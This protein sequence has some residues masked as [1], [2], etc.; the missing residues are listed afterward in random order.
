MKTL[1]TGGGGFI[2][3][4]LTR[5]LLKAGVQVRIL[6]QRGPSEFAKS[7]LGDLLDE[8]EWVIGDVVQAWH[9]ANAVRGCDSV[10]HLAAVL[11]PFCQENPIRGAEIIVIGTLNMFEAARLHGI[12]NVIYTSSAG[13]FGPSDGTYPNPTTHYGAFKLAVEG[14]ARAYFEEQG[15]NSVGF[16]PLLVYGPGRDAGGGKGPTL[17]CRAAAYGESYN[18]P[19]TGITD[20]IYVDDVV[21][22]FES[23]ITKPIKG[24]HAFNLIGE[25]TPIQD[26]VDIIKDIVPGAKVS[27]SG[28]ALPV[29]AYLADNGAYDALGELPRTGVRDGIQQTI[30][31]YIAMKK[32]S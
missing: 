1:I 23:A 20:W 12:K 13:V 6:D 5:R 27:C 3:I 25:Q 4:W 8:V 26:F 24:A 16:R 31:Y 14:C 30:D 15:I 17:S 29:N 32:S 10:V 21:A 19:F 28:E 11:T 7:F 18:I 22:A 2:G 9:V